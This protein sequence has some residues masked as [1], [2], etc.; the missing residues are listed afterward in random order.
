VRPGSAE[1][2]YNAAVAALRKGDRPLARAYA[3]RVLASDPAHAQA[4]LIL[5]KT[6]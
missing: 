3:L 2:A 1:L 4:R 5:G 6:Q